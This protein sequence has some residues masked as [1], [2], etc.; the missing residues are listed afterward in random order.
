MGAGEDR[1][2]ILP[3]DRGQWLG[4]NAEE[5][6]NLAKHSRRIL[7]EVFEEE[8]ADPFPAEDLEIMLHRFVKAGR[9][10]VVEATLESATGRQ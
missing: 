3:F 5:I 6:R 7:V 9:A 8:D 10:P 4:G 2:I 1:R